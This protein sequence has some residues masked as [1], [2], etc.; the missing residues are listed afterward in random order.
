MKLISLSRLF[1]FVIKTSTKYNIDESHALK[2]SMDVY[3]YSHSIFENE[4]KNYILNPYDEIRSKNIM[5]VCSILHDMCDNKYTNEEAGWGFIEELLCNDMGENDINVSKDIIMNMSYSKVI[6]KGF[7]DIFQ[8][9]N[10]LFIYHVVR[11]GDLLASYDFERSVIYGM[12]KKDLDYQESFIESEKLFENR[13]FKYIDHNFFV[14]ESVQPKAQQMHLDAK[15]RIID[16][17][18]YMI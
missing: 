7:P 18:K 6:K 14:H 5:N 11:Q 13:V 8:N 17:R 16:L 9:K 2:H 4:K 3:Y 15:N 12:Y 10:D 1:D